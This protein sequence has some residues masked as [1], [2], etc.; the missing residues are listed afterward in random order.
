M[1]HVKGSDRKQ[2]QNPTNSNQT[3]LSASKDENIRLS[4]H[5]F[6]LP[7]GLSVFLPFCDFRFFFFSFFLFYQLISAALT[8][9]SA[10]SRR[11]YAFTCEEYL[12]HL[13][14]YPRFRSPSTLCLGACLCGTHQLRKALSSLCVDKRDRAPVSAESLDED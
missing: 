10:L 13:H 7:L 14:L 1:P 3:K 9:S 12:P 2:R 5:C 8:R 11:T 4:G 6:H